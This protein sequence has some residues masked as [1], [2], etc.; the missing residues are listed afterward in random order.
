MGVTSFFS[1]FVKKI[2][3]NSVV[4]SIPSSIRGLC[5]DLNGTLHPIAQ[6]VFMYQKYTPKT[7]EDIATK[8]RL[9]STKTYA[10]LE[11]DF[12]TEL[13]KE[14]DTVI[15]NFKPYSFIIFAV[16]GIAPIAKINQQRSRRLGAYLD[17]TRSDSSDPIIEAPLLGFTSSSISPGTPFMER[18]HS[19]LLLYLKEKKNSI[20]SDTIFYTSYKEYGEG[21][22]KIFAKLRSEYPFYDPSNQDPVVIWGLDSDLIILSMI[23]PTKN[24]Y[25]ARESF[26]ELVNIESLKEDISGDGEYLIPNDFCVMSNLIG[27]DFLP[28]NN[29]YNTNIQNEVMLAY[30]ATKEVFKEAN[31]CCLTYEDETKDLNVN[32]LFYFFN[33]LKKYESDMAT[34]VYKTQQSQAK[35]FHRT[36]SLLTRAFDEKTKKVDIQKY[37]DFVLEDLSVIMQTDTSTYEFKREYAFAYVNTMLW[38]YTYYTKGIDKINWEFYF[39]YLIAPSISFILEMIPTPQEYLNFRPQNI[40][41]EDEGV[42]FNILPP[43][44]YGEQLLMILPLPTL[45]KIFSSTIKIP[46]FY[47]LSKL[48]FP[49]PEKIDFYED[50]KR[51][52]YE[53]QPILPYLSLE[54]VKNIIEDTYAVMVKKYYDKNKDI[55]LQK[56]RQRF[57]KK[58]A[59]KGGERF[60]LSEIQLRV[61]KDRIH[62]YPEYKY[63]KVLYEEGDYVYFPRVYKPPHP[64]PPALRVIKECVDC[65]VLIQKVKYDKPIL[66]EPVLSPRSRGVQNKKFYEMFKKR[67]VSE[68]NKEPSTKKSMSKKKV[69]KIESKKPTHKVYELDFVA[70]SF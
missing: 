32:F 50:G 41:I 49:I 15:A 51:A 57:D 56:H 30:H 10:Q 65:S 21:E 3:P 63:I 31:N 43:I 55:I 25:L 39:P 61:K 1:Q 46:E 27:N 64:I 9:S 22:H 12:F 18:V 29:I 13:E 36:S 62:L 59:E 38:M 52:K 2:S 54:N 8:K 20:A 6:K 34:N 60:A 37:N 5:F 28:K 14:L 35:F 17:A 4:K 48:I 58:A 45:E 40:L 66:T 16:D 70:S 7:D 69:L 68:A 24:I 47:E 53:V 23:S 11:K 44:D 42:K 19:F 26:N 33:E 67:I